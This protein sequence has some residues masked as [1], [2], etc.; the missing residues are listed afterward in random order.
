MWT[1]LLTGWASSLY[2][3]IAGTNGTKPDIMV[4]IRLLCVSVVAFAIAS[5]L[6]SFIM[7]STA[8]GGVFR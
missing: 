3:Y 7:A 8:Y 1:V 2:L 6:Q 5:V 4:I